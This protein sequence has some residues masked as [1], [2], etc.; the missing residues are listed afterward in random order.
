M[1]NPYTK[2]TNSRLVMS[3]SNVPA[4]QELRN[5]G[6]RERMVGANG[7]FNASSKK[8]LMQQVSSLVEAFS[9]GKVQRR[10]LPEEVMAARKKLVAEAASDKSGEHWKVLGEVIGDEVWTALNREGFARKTLLYKPLGRNE[11]G[12]IRVRQ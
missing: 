6:S 2:N 9:S 1:V 12:R 3:G 8:E 5:P 10:V 4:E 7:E 11:I